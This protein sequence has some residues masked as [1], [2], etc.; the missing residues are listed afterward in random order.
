[1]IL[2][3]KDYLMI[4]FDKFSK[5]A[6][7]GTEIIKYELQK[8]LPP[9]L[10]N[11]FQIIC[12]RVTELKQNK[13]RL[14]WVHTTADQVDTRHL[15]NRGWDK[16]H[17]IIFISHYQKEDY[18][19]TY[20]I[21]PSHC[22]VIPH[23][24]H[25]IQVKEKSKELQL[26]YCSTPHRGLSLLI[27]VFDEISSYYDITLRVHSSYSIYGWN[28]KQQEFER[29]SLYQRLNQHPKI[30]NLGFTKHNELLNS[31]SQSH[32]FAYPCI[33]KETFCLSL[34]EALSARCLAV[35]PDY[36]CLP[37]TASNWSLMYNYNE[38]PIQHKKLFK[39][40]L[41]D[42]IENYSSYE[43]HLNRQKEYVDSFYDWN[44]IIPKWIS[45]LES[46]QTIKTKPKLQYY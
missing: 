46:I 36:S 5:P 37:E 14:F 41:I 4:E 42:A 9:E 21:P 30:Q 23:G 7:G 26:I 18:Q 8:R 31:L 43:T 27:D 44:I 32:I 2:K 24:I 29:S 35:H 1:M 19:R 13:I 39:K 15:A 45:F 40:T 10:L 16:F 22:I 33:Y 38:N 17:K 25:P 20:R 11:Q 6:I 12:D 34:L 28:E 3:R